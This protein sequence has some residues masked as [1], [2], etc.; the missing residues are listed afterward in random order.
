MF[1]VYVSWLIKNNSSPSVAF[2]SSI[3]WQVVR[4]ALKK[5]SFSLSKCAFLDL[6][7]DLPNQKLIQ[8]EFRP[9]A[10]PSPCLCCTLKS[11]N[12][13]SRRIPLPLYDI[14]SW[15]RPGQLSCRR[16]SGC[17]PLVMCNFFLCSL[18]SHSVEVRCWVLMRI[19]CFVKAVR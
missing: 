10:P 3:S 14:L 19:Q 9:S 13:W 7:P 16:C 6:T 2:T 5:I 15:K 18:H 1:S 4:N 8:P 17:F 12:R 11:E